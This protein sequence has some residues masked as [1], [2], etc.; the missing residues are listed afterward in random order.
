MRQ[1]LAH[2]SDVPVQTFPDKAVILSEGA[3][4]GRIYALADGGLE[5][6]RGE[7]QIATMRE[8]GALVGEMS[9]LLDAPH[10]ATVRTIGE[11]RLHVVDDGVAFL[12]AKP[13]LSWLV[14]RLLARRLNAASTYLADLKKQFSG[15]GNHLEMVGEVLDSLMHDLP[16]RNAG[17]GSD[18]DDYQE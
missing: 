13:E 4:T 12:A 15:Y 3:K 14:A 6:L 2:F 11:T 1:I 9:A 7:T 17:L 8:P 10:T 18:R 16:R 5:V